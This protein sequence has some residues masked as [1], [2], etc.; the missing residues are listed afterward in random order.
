M[1]VWSALTSAFKAAT[2]SKRRDLR[3]STVG[4]TFASGVEPPGDKNSRQARPKTFIDPREAAALLACSDVPREW[5]EVYAVG[6]YTY[7]RPGELRVLTWADDDLDVGHI[8]I[9]KA[10]DYADEKVEPPKSRM[11][12]RKVPIAPELAPLL[13]RM[14]AAAGN[15]AEPQLVVPRLTQ[16]GEDHLADQFRR[17][18]RAANVRR[19]ELHASTVTL[20][21]RSCRDSGITW[22][23]MAGLGVDEIQHRAGHDDVKTTLG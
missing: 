17:R 4:Q 16:F 1:N 11:G 3:V 21:L 15:G 2:S 9:T 22:L 5:R 20:Q 8:S 18:L 6:S 13:E 12:V 7:L 23:A 14:R 19:A 10:W